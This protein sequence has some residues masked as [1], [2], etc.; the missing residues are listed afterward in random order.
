MQAKWI[1]VEQN[2]DQWFD[3]RL[4]KATA[5]HFDEICAF[6]KDLKKLGETAKKYA[7]VKAL[8]QV[9]GTLDT[10]TRMN[11]WQFKRGHELEPLAIQKYEYITGNKVTNGGFFYTDKYG[12]SPDGLIGSD[13]GIEVKSVIVET[14]WKLLDKGGYD[15]KYKMQIQGHMLLSE[16]TEID[17]V[18]FC[19]EFTP[20][21]IHIF[22]VN[23]DEELQDLL[24][25][26][27]NLFDQ[28][29]KMW[30]N[31]ITEKILAA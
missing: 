17:F 14:H 2:S 19:P 28:E 9:T 26:K 16:R 31:N 30:V 7:R 10:S 23:R 22:T 12:D 3:L 29:V 4:G 18:S 15:T 24:R 5:S 25:A 13:S 6:P 1:D 27:L 21:P 8:E 11:L 20:K